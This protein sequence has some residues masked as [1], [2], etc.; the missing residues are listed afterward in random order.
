[1][2]KSNNGGICDH[3]VGGGKTLIMC[4]GAQEMKRLGL[5]H[6]PMIIALKANVHEIAETYRKAYPFAKI[7]YPGKRTSHPRKGLRFLA[8]SRT[9]I[10]TAL[11]SHMTS[12]V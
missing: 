3:E 4:A 12:L 7:L 10:G 8:I 5:V 6:K 11:S 1:M 9:M 2:L